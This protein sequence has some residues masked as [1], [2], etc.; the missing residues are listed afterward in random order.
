MSIYGRPFNGHQQAKTR[1]PIHF[2]PK[3]S[4]GRHLGRYASEMPPTPEQ[5]A[6]AQIDALLTAAGWVIQDVGAFNRNAA[7]G[8]A[9]REFVLPRSGATCL[10][11][12]EI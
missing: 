1:D 2:W 5:F 3:V 12:S 9:V 6:R 7:E 11:V 8:V 10:V 4:P